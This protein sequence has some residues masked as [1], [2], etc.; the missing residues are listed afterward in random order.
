VFGLSVVFVQAQQ[1]ALDLV[2]SLLAEFLVSRCPRGL[3][4]VPT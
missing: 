4:Q 3:G 2:E 1:L